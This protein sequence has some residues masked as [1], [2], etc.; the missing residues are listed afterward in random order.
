MSQGRE[1]EGTGGR[2]GEAG[3]VYLP[4]IHLKP[5]CEPAA[6]SEEGKER[7]GEGRGGSEG[8]GGEAG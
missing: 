3:S 5:T 6:G 7:G 1:R 4:L 2:R 8:A